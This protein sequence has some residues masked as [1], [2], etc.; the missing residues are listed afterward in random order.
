M[1]ECLQCGKLLYSFQGKQIQKYCSRDCSVARQHKRLYEYNENFFDEWNDKM[2]Y[3]L[4]FIYADGNI[5]G[6]LKNLSISQKDPEILY[7]IRDLMEGNL[8]IIERKRE[9]TSYYLR[10][11]NRRIVDSLLKLGVFPNKSTRVQFPSIPDE[12]L[13]HF[14][15]GLWDGDGSIGPASNAPYPY[16]VAQITSGSREFLESLQDVLHDKIGLPILKITKI[17]DVNAYRVGYQGPACKTLYE[18]LYFYPHGTAV[19]KS[20]YLERKYKKFFESV[21]IDEITKNDANRKANEERRINIERL[22]KEN[23]DQIIE[24]NTVRDG[25]CLIWE[26][27]RKRK[28][29]NPIC[30]YYSG[31]Y[32]YTIKQFIYKHKVCDLYPL[33]SAQQIQN[34]CRN[35]RCVEPSHLLWWNDPKIVRQIKELYWGDQQ[36]SSPQIA[37]AFNTNHHLI[38][39]VMKRNNI[40]LRTMV[41]AVRIRKTSDKRGKQLMVR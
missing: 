25:T 23:I 8:R 11:I 3:V 12:Y 10:L 9:R 16:P 18:F 26:R 21:H 19:P 4:G 22:I 35:W 33:Y 15:R 5:S 27:I 7:K 40:E 6:D 39:N 29:G 24:D 31:S 30:I 28:N 36:L 20:M 37:E 2:A 17:K 41:E 34:T 13:R 38:Q 14:V 1:K 32:A